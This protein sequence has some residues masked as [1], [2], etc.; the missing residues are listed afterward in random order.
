MM[1]KA[2]I[3]VMMMLMMMWWWRNKL[4]NRKWKKKKKILEWLS[5]ISIMEYQ[6]G[7]NMKT[8]RLLL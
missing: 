3:M 4:L 2:T 1:T 8:T 7:A 5:K 6:L